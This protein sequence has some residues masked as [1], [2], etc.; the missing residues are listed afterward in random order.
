MIEPTID[1][2]SISHYKLPRKNLAHVMIQAA[3][4]DGG[5]PYYNLEYVPVEERSSWLAWN[6]LLGALAGP[7]AAQL[8]GTTPAMILFGGLRLAIALAIFRWG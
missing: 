7:A 8:T 3:V 6:L 1:Y 2:R 5:P 4:P